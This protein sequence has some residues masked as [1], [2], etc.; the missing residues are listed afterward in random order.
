M[1]I[2]RE[3]TL[4]NN[5]AGAARYMNGRADTQTGTIIKRTPKPRL[6]TLITQWI[7]FAWLASESGKFPADHLGL[8]RM[9]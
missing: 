6:S 1:L 9:R 5:P 3:I 4:P 7:I 8:L 2:A